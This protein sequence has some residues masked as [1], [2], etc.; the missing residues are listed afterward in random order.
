MSDHPYL[1]RPRPTI[2]T[3]AM[4]NGLTKL[5]SAIEAEY[6]G[7]GLHSLTRIGKS[8]LGMYIVNNQDWLG[9][10]YFALYAL[11]PLDLKVGSGA[12]YEYLFNGL[13]VAISTRQSPQQKLIR[14]VHT[15]IT[16]SSAV[17]TK[18][19]VLILDEA[20]RLERESF[21]HLVSIDNE[22]TVRGYTLFAVLL[23]QDNHTSGIV[24]K[25][26]NLNVSP[27]VKARFLTRY[28]L[29]HGIRGAAD[30]S[31]FIQRLEEETEHPPKSGISFPRHFA[32][33]LYARGWRMAP[34][35]HRVWERGNLA[36]LSVGKSSLDEWP[37]KPFELAIYYLVTRVIV[38]ED[39]VDF[40][41][42]DLDAAIEFSDLVAFDG[43]SG[44]VSD[45]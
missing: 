33:E 16:R 2:P 43:F 32:P 10:A 13:G 12:F 11:V 19:I 37:M 15:L 6:R 7:A 40:T 21:E 28:H 14:L 22:L 44:D 3:A 26:N 42:D 45:C 17:R 20:N 25:I 29:M 30:I 36:R 23:F 9:Y 5:A 41:D 24:E 1:Q 31:L 27:Q 39:F 4:E 18:L 34:S 35:S 8:S 38:R